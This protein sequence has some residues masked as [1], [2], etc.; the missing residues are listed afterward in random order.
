[1]TLNELDRWLSDTFQIPAWEG[2]DSSLNGLQFG[3]QNPEIRKTAFAVD[4]CLATFQA[5]AA[6]GADILIVHHGLFWGRP[7]AWTGDAYRRLRA[8]TDTD[9][10]LYAIHLPLDAH[11]ELGN[12]IGMARALGL[13]EIQP[14][15][16][17]KGTPIGFRGI[18]PEPRDL[19]WIAARLIG[20]REQAL[21]ILPF[22]PKLIRSVGLISGGAPHEVAEAIRLGLDLYVTGDASHV[23]YHQAREAGINVL[24]GGHYATETYG[25][26]LL[27][28][29]LSKAL[30]L[31]TVFLDIPT[32]L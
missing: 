22:G 30:G 6:Q 26:R 9:L 2:R 17:Y 13:E 28:D 7:F 5:A 23:I 10:A 14:F 3:R 16:A 15:G 21:Q 27:A 25:V 31:D 11:P 18:L 1:M 4:A 19:D 12:N 20:G 32:G 8:L 29:R 24:F